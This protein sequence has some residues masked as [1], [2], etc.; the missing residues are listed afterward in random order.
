MTGNVCANIF[1]VGGERNRGGVEGGGV[2]GHV[3][4]GEFVM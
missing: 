3:H 2:G 4:M 1:A